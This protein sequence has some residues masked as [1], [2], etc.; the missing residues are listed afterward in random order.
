MIWNLIVVPTGTVVL[1]GK[2][3][4]YSTPYLPALPTSIVLA[5]GACFV[6][7]LAIL[8]SRS[9]CAFSALASAFALGIFLDFG[10]TLMT[11][12]IPG[13]RSQ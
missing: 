5:G 11:P 6:R 1:P 9:I 12:S 3:L 8:K 13:C 2:K 10:R 7:P 4:K